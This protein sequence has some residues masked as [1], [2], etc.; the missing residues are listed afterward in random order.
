MKLKNVNTFPDVKPDKDQAVKVLEESSELFGAW[1]ML[2]SAKLYKRS[3]KDVENVRRHFASEAADAITAICNL[4]KA[5]GIDDLRG[6]L[7]SCE[8]RNRIRGRY[9]KE[10]QVGK[11]R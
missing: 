9:G 8:A 3:D 4:A 1:Q 7:E 11:R 10:A 6:A 5:E 2:E